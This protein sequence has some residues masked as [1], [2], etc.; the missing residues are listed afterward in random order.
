MAHHGYKSS[1]IF[2][3]S[4]VAVFPRVAECQIIYSEK[5]LNPIWLGGGQICPHHHVFAHT[6]VCMRIQVLIFFDFSSFWVW[7]R[8]Q[9]FWPQK[10]ALFSQE[11]QKRPVLIGLKP[12]LRSVAKP[13]TNSVRQV[14]SKNYKNSNILCHQKSEKYQNSL[15]VGHNNVYILAEGMRMHYGGWGLDGV[16]NGG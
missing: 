12:N 9:H 7:K 16:V 14:V 2:L 4:K 8:V 15:L 1:L 5:T 10:N 3:P 13:V 11:N 6:S